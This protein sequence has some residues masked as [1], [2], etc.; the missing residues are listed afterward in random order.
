MPAGMKQ[1]SEFIRFW[2]L[3]GHMIERIFMINFPDLLENFY[4]FN[5]FITCKVCVSGYPV[6]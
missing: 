6:L 1:S 2:Q 3:F 5:L 4:T